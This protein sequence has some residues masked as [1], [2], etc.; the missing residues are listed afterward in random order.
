M[1]A[2]DRPHAPE[3]AAGAF[4]GCPRDRLVVGV[5]DEVAAGR[6]LDPVPARLEAVEEEPLGDAVFRR[7]GLDRDVVVDEQVGGT[8]ALLTRVDPEGEVVEA[9]ASA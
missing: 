8:E 5:E 7:G 1:K 3:L 4:L 9:P 6:D 2:L